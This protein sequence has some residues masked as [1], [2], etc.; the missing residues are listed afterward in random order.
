MGLIRGGPI[1]W[2]RFDRAIFQQPV[3]D[4]MVNMV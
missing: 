2:F 1:A 4:F 3:A